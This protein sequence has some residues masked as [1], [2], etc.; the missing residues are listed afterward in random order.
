V[1]E[2][3]REALGKREVWRSLKTDSLTVA[4]R[5]SHGVA[6]RIEQEFE[7]ARARLGFSVDQ[8]LLTPSAS[9]DAPETAPSPPSRP[10]D[11]GQSL[12]SVYDA[13]MADPTRDWSPRTRFA[14]E[15][16]RR[17]AVAVLELTPRSEPSRERSAGS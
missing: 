15:T 10:V 3:L 7:A 8:A 12:A 16:T 14:Y 13:Y 9:R 2:A 17:V 11:Q 6:A 4:V 1:P 5:R